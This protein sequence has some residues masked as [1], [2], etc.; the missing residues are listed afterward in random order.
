MPVDIV[1]D[2]YGRVCIA[3][4]KVGL[5]VY[6]VDQATMFESN[7]YYFYDIGGDITS[8]S[9]GSTQYGTTVLLGAVN[10]IA[11]ITLGT[12]DTYKIYP[13]V[14]MYSG[15]AD[16]YGIVSPSR[17]FAFV[18]NIWNK[19]GVVHGAFTVLDKDNSYN[20]T[21]VAE[22]GDTYFMQNSTNIDPYAP[23]TI[24]TDSHNDLLYYYIRADNDGV[25]CFTVT[26]GYKT[27]SGQIA[28][29][30]TFNLLAWERYDHTQNAT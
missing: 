8:V 4:Q 24:F 6:T 27:M 12:L 3:D 1:V 5:V 9:H 2:D 18:N 21:T 14:N 29:D 22:W 20:T 19:E 16:S 25:R 10:G 23:Y 15:S 17:Q 11:E 7:W 26:I 28:E 13:S 30:A